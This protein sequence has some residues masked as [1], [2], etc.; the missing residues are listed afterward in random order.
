MYPDLGSEDVHFF[1]THFMSNYTSA[2]VS[3]SQMEKQNGKRE[4]E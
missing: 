2:A 4:N 3:V 1:S